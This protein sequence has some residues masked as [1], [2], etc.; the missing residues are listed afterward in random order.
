MRL[1]KILIVLALF[2]Y[3]QCPAQISI[4]GK[5]IDQTTFCPISNV[6]VCIRQIGE[7]KIIQFAESNSDGIYEIKLATFPQNHQLY[8]SMMGF[9]PQTIL[10]KVD[11]SVYNVKLKEKITELK[12]VIIKEPKIHQRGDT[13][14]YCVSKFADIQDKTLADVLKK[15]PGIEVVENG[16][17]K[18]NSVSINKFYIEGKDM[19]GGQYGIAT[20]NI[21]Q[22]DVDSVIVM[23]NHQPIKALEDISFSYNPAINIRLK[24]DAKARWVGTAKGGVGFD[25]FL[26]NAE[27][28]LMRFK[29]NTQTL[30][31]FKTNS[32]GNDITQETMPMSTDDIFNQFSKNYRLL[33]YLTFSTENL[34]GINRS[35][36]R[37]NETYGL[38]TNN[39]WSFGKN[40]D[41]KSQIIYT[42][43]QLFSENYTH[44]SY[45]LEDSN[46]ITETTE[47]ALSKQNRLYGDITLT[48]NTRNYYFKNKLLTDL[49][50]DNNN[51]NISGTFPNTQTSFFQHRQISN[52]FDIIIR[53]REIA[54][55]LNSYNLY[56]IK[57]QQ[58][59]LTK[60]SGSQQ[61]R[62]YSSAFYSN[63]N[64]ALSFFLNPVTISIRLGLLGVDRALETELKGIP[65]TLGKLR[66]DIS[67][68]YL[69]L[70]ISPE[71]EYR[72]SSFEAKFNIPASF[73]PYC[74]FD[75]I[76]NEKQ[77]ENKFFLAP[78]LYIRYH[79][80]SCLSASFSGVHTQRP[81][82][83]QSFYEGLILNNY[84]NISQG[85]VSFRTG[86]SQSANLNINYRNPLKAFFI[87][88]N[89]MR[90][91][92]YLP[93]SSNRFFLDEYVLNTF[94][95]KKYHSDMWMFSGNIS[96]SVVAI[97]GI[98]TVQTSF[99]TFNGT[100][101]QNGKE[102]PYFS[103]SWYIA[104]KITNRLAKW[105]NLTYE[106]SF[107][108]NWLQIEKSPI[109]T[110][111]INLSQNFS[112]N[113]T[114]KKNWLLQFIGEH[115]YNEM[116]DG[117]SKHFFLA[118]SEFTYTFKGGWEFNFLIKNIFNQNTYSYTTFDRLSEMNR[119]FKIRPRNI[120]ASIYFKF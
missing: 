2:V 87:N 68:H 103:N 85:L 113:I 3:F 23:E 47:K 37:F 64:T 6:L 33:D 22:K 50:W 54:Y 116:P 11:Q 32:I 46:I 4:T 72:K 34:Q 104:P 63:T 66:N 48:A 115:Y 27:L 31:T 120:I 108:Q 13:I 114:P 101:S 16:T 61:Q 73:V 92:N 21:H 55:T 44:T 96:K 76:S 77:D 112:L 89:I 36:S 28:A 40:Y 19:L 83:E 10:L 9:A 69:N 88:A 58:L 100:M 57:P 93:F 20:N 105:Y 41:L 99:S 38:S 30:N 52:D 42:N 98:I 15:M 91:W 82:D 102:L 118:D 90:S 56:Q 62:I 75:K 5:I 25:P 119:E 95:Q 97:K 29:K 109:Q 59:T 17:V 74:Y 67:I 110:S 24:E 26:W 70:Y 84:Q 45:F 14:S 106:L 107:T 51:M 94:I 35:R 78:K 18:Y 12:E 65:D 117:V 39:L 53:S 111:F 79:F 86:N 8:C 60:S 80:T 43:N 49:R 1:N 81:I 71:I 7:N